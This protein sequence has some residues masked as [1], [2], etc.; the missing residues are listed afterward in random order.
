M[1]LTIAIDDRTRYSPWCA[2]LPFITA[3]QQY[4]QTTLRSDTGQMLGTH[5]YWIGDAN[6][7][8]LHSHAG[9]QSG[10]ARGEAEPCAPND[11]ESGLTNGALL[12]RLAP[13]VLV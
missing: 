12:A 3:R 9:C 5:A 8:R 10:T 13:D 7:R 11:V 6:E 4:S 1:A 2:S